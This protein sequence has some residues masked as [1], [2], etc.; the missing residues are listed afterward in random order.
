MTDLENLD[1]FGLLD[2]VGYLKAEQKWYLGPYLQPYIWYNNR[3]QIWRHK[4]RS[5]S[6]LTSFLR[7]SISPLNALIRSSFN[8]SIAST[9]SLL[10]LS[11]AV[12]VTTSLLLLSE[13]RK[14]V[15]IYMPI[16]EKMEKGRL[17]ILLSYKQK[18]SEIGYKTDDWNVNRENKTQ[19][20][21][22][23]VS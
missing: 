20:R 23:R 16:I 1:Y 7:D 10:L 9:T 11:E 18:H 15:Y 13:T 14:E 8:F 3:V 12:Y 19:I 17:P 2:I 4:I 21:I 6:P 5:N 22:F